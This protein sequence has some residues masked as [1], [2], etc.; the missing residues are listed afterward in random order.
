VDWLLF[1]ALCMMWLAFLV[2]IG[3]R[4]RSPK[5]SVHHF[6]RGMELL[7]QVETRHEGPGRWIVTPRKGMPFLGRDGRRRA[8]ARERRRHVFVFLLEFIAIT[9]LIGLVPPLR[10]IFWTL[11]TALAAALVLYTWVL[12]WIK[13]AAAVRM[14]GMLPHE[15]IRAAAAN[16]PVVDQVVVVPDRYVAEAPSVRARATYNGLNLL[17]ADERVHVVVRP[18]GSMAGA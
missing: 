12:L 10:P 8:R 1:A 18:A 5:V 7:A 16:G 4:R 17:D 15:R 2:P 14:A 13:R 3:K 11:A 9:L 6:E